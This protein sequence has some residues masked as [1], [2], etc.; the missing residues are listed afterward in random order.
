VFSVTF[1]EFVNDVVTD[2][3]VPEFIANTSPELSVKAETVHVLVTEF[4]EPP[5]DEIHIVCVRT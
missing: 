2:K 3:V 4:H 1:P 5:S